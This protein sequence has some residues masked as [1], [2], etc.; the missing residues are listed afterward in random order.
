[1]KQ[2]WSDA[3]RRLKSPACP[4]MKVWAYL[5]VCTRVP[6]HSAFL[7]SGGFGEARMG[8]FGT[9][10]CLRSGRRGSSGLH[11]N[12]SPALCQAIVAKPRSGE[13]CHFPHVLKKKNKKERN[14]VK[15][16]K[17]LIRKPSL[18]SSHPAAAPRFTSEDAP[19]RQ[20]HM[21]HPPPH[22]LPGVQPS[23][24]GHF[25]VPVPAGGRSAR[26]C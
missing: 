3:S 10:L 23:L 7:S 16:S 12:P 8:I 6:V 15:P 18:P 20:P 22:T 25:G 26:G 11:M 13:P 14:K 24:R 9:S 1:M 5:L 21:G 2:P 17:I 19:P 4:T